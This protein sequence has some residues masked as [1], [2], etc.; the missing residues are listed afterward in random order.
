MRIQE[1][2]ADA[3]IDPGEDDDQSDGNPAAAPVPAAVGAARTA[4][5]IKTGADLREWQA[6]LKGMNKKEQVWRLGEDRSVGELSRDRMQLIAIKDKSGKELHLKWPKTKD[7]NVSVDNMLR[8]I[9]VKLCHDFPADNAGKADDAPHVS[10]QSRVY[11]R[12]HVPDRKYFPPPLPEPPSKALTTL[13]R[14][15]LTR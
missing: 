1:E 10:A 8:M 12:G 3:A 15:E 11:W 6:K 5:T 13:E 9:E 7:T 2:E 4:S 14:T